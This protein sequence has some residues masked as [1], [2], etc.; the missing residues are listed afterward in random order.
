MLRLNLLRD[1][2]PAAPENP[3]PLRPPRRAPL[4]LLGLLAIGGAGLYLAKSQN[5]DPGGMLAALG[6]DKAAREAARADSLR[7][8]TVLRAEASRL[9]AER[10][11]LAIEWLHQLEAA[12]PPDSGE[13][14]VTLSSFTPPGEFLL[15]GTAR[16]SE[17]L[18][19]LQEALVLLPGMDL[20]QSQ[21]DEIEGDPA[22]SFSFLFAGSL[23]L[24]QAEEASDSMPP[25]DR[26]RSAEQLDENLA[27]WLRSAAPA[28]V[29]FSPP[30]A[31][32]ETV[33][34]TLRI[35]SWRLRGSCD[36]VGFGAVRALLEDQHIQGSPFG[37]RRITLENRG[38]RKTAILDIMAFT[39]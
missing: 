29:A 36:S 9:T 28:G 8:A 38:G 22:G 23:D 11:V 32:G 10:Q 34:G 7:R 2:A 1:M 19:T 5:F 27:S 35:H 15:R 24:G 26:V 16:N 18:A 17:V 4:I 37:L 12:L 30:E 31:G 21:A 14:V 33:A 25:M 13:Y 3:R 39:P 6:G 20:R